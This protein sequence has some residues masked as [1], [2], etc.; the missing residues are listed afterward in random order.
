MASQ[1]GVAPQKNLKSVQL[2]CEMMLCRS[3]SGS[4][5]FGRRYRIYI[6]DLHNTDKEE[7]LFFHNLFEQSNL[8]MFRTD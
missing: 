2:S 5:R 7:A 8:Y 3:M 1:T 4:R 6:P